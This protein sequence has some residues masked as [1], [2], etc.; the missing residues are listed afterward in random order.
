[1]RKIIHRAIL[2]IIV[3]LS[4]AA[5]S[6]ATDGY[7]NTGYGVIQQGQG[8]AGVALPSDSLVGATNPAGLALVGDRFDFGLTLFRPFRDASITGNELPEGFPDV[9]GHYDANRVK[10]FFVPELGFSH[11]LSPRLALGVSI[12]GNGG[13]NTSYTTPIFL[14]GTTRGGVDLEQLF[15][16]PTIAFKATEHNAFGLAV[17]I[18]Y[19]RFSAEG[20][21]NFASPSYS[22]AP[23]Y[24]TNTGYSNSYG[25]GVRV[26]WLGQLTPIVSVGATFQTETYASKF[27]RY[28]GLFAEQ[29]GFDIPANAAAGVSLKVSPEV[30]VLVDGEGIFYGQVRAIANLDSNQAPLGASD[31]PGFGWHDI[32]AIKTGIDYQVTHSLTVRGGY[33]HSSL[34]FDGTQTFFNLLAPA[35]VQNHLHLGATWTSQSGKELSIAYVHAFGENVNGV[36]SIPP[37]AGGGNA[38]LHMYQNSI[39]IGFG[40][41]RNKK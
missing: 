37:T 14:L 38:N 29:G 28:R 19:Q 24:V 11:S 30:T 13:M 41:N 27:S 3:L 4:I 15:L 7:F 5:P 8:G 32:A 39:E 16:S 10:N 31:G 25:A 2:S 20:L 22:S 9:N 33:N 6:F 40:W 26:G 1:M 18:V 34:P 21:Q 17:N 35:V 23:A 36:D 12:F